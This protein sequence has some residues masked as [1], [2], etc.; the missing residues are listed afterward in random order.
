MFPGY[1]TIVFISQEPLNLQKKKSSFE[2]K[3]AVIFTV[4][5]KKKFLDGIF[6]LQ[7]S[8]KASRL[9]FFYSTKCRLHKKA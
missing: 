6:V 2:K 8:K 3:Y 1:W 7:K 5:V 9:P 4:P